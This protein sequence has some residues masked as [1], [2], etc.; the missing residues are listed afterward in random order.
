MGLFFTSPALAYLFRANLKKP[1]VQACWIGVVSVMLPIITYY[2]VG[3]VQFGYR[4]ALDFIPFLLLLT[5][6]GLPRP[7]TN[8]ARTLVLVS[9]A[10]NIWGAIFFSKWV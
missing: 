4:Y 6:L 2:G 5:A 10:V 3:W 1:F 9:V 7:M 8:A